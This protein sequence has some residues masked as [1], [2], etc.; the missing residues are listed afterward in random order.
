[1]LS[2]IQLLQKIQYLFSC[3]GPNS[4]WYR[5]IF[6]CILLRSVKKSN[7]IREIC[8]CQ[9]RLSI[10]SATF[11]VSRQTGV[12]SRTNDKTITLL[13][14]C[15]VIIRPFIFTEHACNVPFNAGPK[16]KNPSFRTR[17]LHVLQAV[18]APSSFRAPGSRDRWAPRARAKVTAWGRGW[19]DN[20]DRQD[21]FSSWFYTFCRIND[22]KSNVQNYISSQPW[23][24][25]S[26]NPSIYIL[27]N[28]P[29]LFFCRFFFCRFRFLPESHHR[30]K[31]PFQVVSH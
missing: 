12:L 4:N 29:T 7:W 11:N 5:N 28:L 10:T 17:A 21:S 23:L 15:H 19:N 22:F 3:L 24:T 31:C 1:M 20:S 9:Q 8:S 25:Y 14:G 18:K 2:H 13:L 6:Y 27:L 30:D 16:A 26:V